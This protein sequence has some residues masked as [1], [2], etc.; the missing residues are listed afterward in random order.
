MPQGVAEKA[1]VPSAAAATTMVLLVVKRKE[2]RTF[3]LLSV[4]IIGK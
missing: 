2:P 1:V 4:A 3:A